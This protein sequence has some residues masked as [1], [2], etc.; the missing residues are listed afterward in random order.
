MIQ[1]RDVSFSRADRRILHHVHADC[2]SP[3]ITV[4]MAPSG[5]GK[6]TLL[7]LL[8]GDLIADS[9]AIVGTDLLGPPSWVWQEHRLL[10]W[11]TVRDN[12]LLPHRHRH[13]RDQLPRLEELAT[14]FAMDQSLDRY[15]HQLSGGM[16]RRAALLR[17]LLWPASLYLWDEP[18]AGLDEGLRATL[19][20]WL[21]RYWQE[22][23]ATAIVAL[24]DSTDARQLG[25]T[26]LELPPA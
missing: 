12:I 25:A 14:I 7:H 9:G 1:L 24:H 13:R 22:Q 10:P 26:F 16:A 18:F 5:R 17:S 15:P 3:G 6:T 20:P 21:A 4:L 2:P 23:G 11:L 19:I 8:A